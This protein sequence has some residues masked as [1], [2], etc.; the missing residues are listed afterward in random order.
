MTPAP[1]T[2]A[3]L[4][5]ATTAVDASRVLN[6][7]D[8]LPDAIRAALDE[9]HA[10]LI[11]LL[12]LL[13]AHSQA[14]APSSASPYT[15]PHLRAARDR[16]W[17]AAEEVHHAYHHAPRPDDPASGD[18]IAACRH[19]LPEGAPELTICHRHLRAG[20]RVRRATTSA[21]LRTPVPRPIRHSL[22]GAAA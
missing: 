17:Q 21:A 4:S 19:G 1:S 16:V 5:I 14:G 13:E 2:R 20:T 18:D 22:A 10:H 15:L 7:P 9:L 3:F 8:V 11:A 12:R 6:L